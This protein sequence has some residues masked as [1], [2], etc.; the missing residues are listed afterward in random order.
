MRRLFLLLGCVC[1]VLGCSR[2]DD[3]VVEKHQTVWES[4]RP[5]E[6]VI[7]VCGTGFSGGCLVYAVSD[8]KVIAASSKLGDGAW[9]ASDPQS[10]DEPV[11]GLFRG[12]RAHDGCDRTRL[13]F[14]ADFGF[15][16]DVYFDCGEEGF[17]Q[18]VSCFEPNS[19]DPTVCQDR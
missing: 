14:D 5:A 7:Q 8:Q 17:G 4:K 12:A 13:A 19:V 16:T 11:A 18:K 2:D 3:S 6:Y 9:T 15:V 1:S 10:H